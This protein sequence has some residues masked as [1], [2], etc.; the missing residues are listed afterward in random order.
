MSNFTTNYIQDELSSGADT[1]SSNSTP[2]F[3]RGERLR[4][5]EIVI[6]DSS[7]DND[8]QLSAVSES[9]YDSDLDSENVYDEINQL[10]YQHFYAEKE[11]GNYYIGMADYDKPN[12]SL[13]FSTTISP[14][15]YF[16]YS[17]R[18]C[19]RYLYYYGI[20]QQARPSIDIMQLHIDSTGTFNVVIKTFWL[21]LVQRKW[22]KIYKQRQQ[23]IQKR[24]CPGALLHREIIGN[25]QHDIA[26]LPSILGLLV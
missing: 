1:V 13:L 9:D 4:F 22:K 15:A 6:V 24:S 25:W 12:G 14:T 5:D 21:K 26:H 20:S 10:D 3:I 2:T 19:S 8:S 7:D 16:Q 18:D 23:I 17:Y 11:D